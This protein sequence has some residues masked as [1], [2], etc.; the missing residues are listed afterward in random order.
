MPARQWFVLLTAWLWMGDAPA[1][2]QSPPATGE[3]CEIPLRAVETVCGHVRTASG[4]RLRTITTRP[5]AAGTRRLPAVLFIPWLSCDPVTIPREGAD[6]W[7]ETLQVLAERSGMVVARTEKAGLAGSEGPA[8]GDLGYDEELA[9]HRAALAA[10]RQSPHVHPDS[11][12]LFGG[13]MGGTMAPALAGGGGIRGI[14]V[15]GTTAKTWAEHMVELDRRVLELRNE[16]PDSI[17]GRMGDHMLFHARYLAEG[18]HPARVAG[19]RPALARAWARMLGTD[20]RYER[21]YGRSVRF[22]QEA[23]RANWAGAWSSVRVPVLV[24]HG[25]FDWIMSPAEHRHLAD[26]VNRANPGGARL[27]TVPATDHNFARVASARAAF[28]GG[29]HPFNPDAAEVILQ[30]LRTRG[31]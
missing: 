1:A 13:S 24:V 3:A 12:Y 6:G 26:L 18:V 29:T 9:G 15:W 7:A 20:P 17:G 8:C 21:Q 5:V 25:E 19:E 27:V 23:Q 16:D 30:W 31:R 22:H 2:A 14:V 10:L 4:Y 11:I 28:Q